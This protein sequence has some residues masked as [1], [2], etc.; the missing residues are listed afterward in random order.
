MK[1]WRIDSAYRVEI[2]DDY[3]LVDSFLKWLV[4]NPQIET[5]RGGSSGRG[6]CIMWFPSEYATD[7]ARFFSSSENVADGKS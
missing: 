4:D 3:D 2:V 7:L 5:F 6:N 1:N